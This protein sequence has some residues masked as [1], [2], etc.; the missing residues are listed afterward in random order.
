MTVGFKP[1][2]TLQFCIDNGILDKLTDN[3]NAD[4]IVTLIHYV[5][6]GFITREEF[7][8]SVKEL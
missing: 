7:V 5:L 1:T 8:R 2:I 4:K 6:M 3:R